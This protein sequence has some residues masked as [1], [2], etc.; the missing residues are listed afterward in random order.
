M[1]I[2]QLDVQQIEAKFDTGIKS[3]L[4]T[5]E[6][7]NAIND[8]QKFLQ[9]FLGAMDECREK[10]S[11]V[12][13]VSLVYFSISIIFSILNRSWSLL[14]CCIAT[15]SLFFALFF[16]ECGVLR[17]LKW[18]YFK[19]IETCDENVCVVRDG[20]EQTVVVSHL[21]IGDLIRLREGTVLRGDARI[22]ASNRLFADESVV[23][24]KTIPSVKTAD[25]ITDDNVLPE[26]QKNMLWKGSFITS[27]EGSAVIVAL[28]DD[29]Y[30]YKTG[31]REKRGQRSYVY[32]QRNNIGRIISLAFLLLCLIAF[33]LAAVISGRWVES[34][35]IFGTLNVLISLEPVSCITEW[36]YFH[37]AQKLYEQGALVRNIQI[38]DGINKEK[39]VYFDVPALLK[40]QLRYQRTIAIDGDEKTALSYFALATNETVDL[41]DPL[42]K[43][44]TGIQKLAKM[45]PV[46]R[47]EEDGCGN[48]FGLLTDRGDSKL[49]AT[50][51][52]RRILPYV[53]PLDDEL[54][55]M[56]EEL[57]IHGKMVYL[58]AANKTD[59]F[60]GS[61]SALAKSVPLKPIAL[62]VLDIQVNDAI[63][64]MIARLK[65]S[66]MRVHLIN[67]NSEHFGK[68]L[69]KIYDMDDFSSAIPEKIN[70]SI[71][72]P[73][74]G[75]VFEDASMI[76][77][78]DAS[79]ILMRGTLP[80]RIL[81]SVKCMFCGISRGLNFL[82]ITAMFLLAGVFALILRGV[83]AHAILFPLLLTQPILV[84]LCYFLTETVRNCNQSKRSLV[85]G[86]LFGAPTLIAAL[87]GCDMTLLIPGL[88]AVLYAVVLWWGALKHRGLK[89]NDL[90]VIFLALLLAIFPWLFIGGNWLVALLL[91]VFPAAAAL[92]LDLIY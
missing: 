76:E 44:D 71:P 19:H 30:V 78:E 67:E 34:F 20:V 53:G 14:A 62:I 50:G 80:Q 40:S 33:L 42:E 3:G 69:C 51:Y 81:Y 18:K 13:I 63:Y 89:L 61:L 68:N 82:G 87:I 9:L 21:K 15:L 52:W 35:A 27:G 17:Y 59:L 47:K 25:A 79:L 12:H 91:S 38:F 65:K 73:G 60:P 10:F 22:V 85:M 37:S 24:G 64:E 46:F 36:N 26:D 31:G 55:K 41:D 77:K 32:N 92:I 1:K 54:T 75:V 2:Y 49:V 29:C 6:T 88:S 8:N 5:E 11:Y 66:G 39:D 74:T 28:D 4:K 84:S 72:A 7:G 48:S 45:S 43:Y 58:L 23:F 16:I 90:L 83:E 57:E 86:A 70:C 56:A